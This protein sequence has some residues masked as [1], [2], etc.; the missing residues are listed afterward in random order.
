MNKKE[1]TEKIADVAELSKTSAAKVLDV[2]FDSISDALLEGD[3]VQLI[4][5]GTFSVGVR[6]AREGRNPMTREPINIPEK[7]YVKF[8]GSSKLSE[9]LQGELAESE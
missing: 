6:S 8:K 3:M 2:V 5:F 9:R 1:L 7:K 4:G